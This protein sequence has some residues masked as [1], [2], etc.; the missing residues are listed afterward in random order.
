MQV[1]IQA[2]VVAACATLVLLFCSFDTLEFTELGLNYGWVT[3]TVDEDVYTFGRYYLGLGHHFI[4]FPQTVRSIVFIDDVT[5]QKHGPALQSR[6]WDGLSVRLEVSFQYKLKPAEVYAMY[7]TLG[8]DYE[9][10]FIRMAIEQITSCA[11]R[12]KAHSFFI[13]RT[14]IAEDMHSMLGQ[15]FRTHGFSDIPFLQL[16]TVHLPIEFENSLMQTQLMEQDIL[17][18]REERNAK[19]VTFETKVLQAEQSVKQISNNALAQAASIL[20][21]ND[22]YC[23]QYGFTQKLQSQGLKHVMQNAEWDPIQLLDYMRIRALRDHP[24]TNSIIKM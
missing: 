11:S 4:K 17:T 24:S 2:V 8:S 23:D 9:Q 1:G 6:T 22:A 18:A 19:S 7:T 16:R 20:V 10:T 3:E 5:S 13:N 21:H 12:Y 14:S 15:H